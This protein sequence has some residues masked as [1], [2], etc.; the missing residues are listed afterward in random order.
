MSDEQ[1]LEALRRMHENQD[2]ADA[3]AT[4]EAWTEQKDRWLDGLA[5]AAPEFHPVAT[6]YNDITKAILYY[7]A[8]FTDNG[9]EALEQIGPSSDTDPRPDKG[10]EA[11]Q[12]M[13]RG[14]AG[15]DVAEQLESIRRYV[16]EKITNVALQ[17][18]S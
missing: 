9:I 10:T 1:A 15:E 2:D 11:L 8:G 14:L 7:Q 18:P 12:L 16:S 17:N 13:K 6:I 4:L 5:E 3:R